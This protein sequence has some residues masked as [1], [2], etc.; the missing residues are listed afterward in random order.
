MIQSAVG[1]NQ[2]IASIIG[3]ADTESDN[4]KLV[5][6]PVDKVLDLIG[7]EAILGQLGIFITD[8]RTDRVELGYRKTEIDTGA[9]NPAV[10]GRDI[11][12]KTIRFL[13]VKIIAS[14]DSVI[15]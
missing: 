3:K 14:A 8:G 9:D 10:V 1:H 11:R 2:I 5:A 15:C 7:K 12:I 13:I 4:V 6:F